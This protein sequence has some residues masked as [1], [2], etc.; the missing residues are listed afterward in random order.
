MVVLLAATLLPISYSNAS[1]S[2]AEAAETPVYDR[3][4]KL[5]EQKPTDSVSFR[6]QAHGGS[7]FDTKRGQLILFGS[8]THGQDWTNSP[9]VF[10][11]NTRQWRRIHANDAPTTYAVNEDGI[12][13]AGKGQHPWAMHAFGAVLYDPARDEMIVASAPKHNTER[14][15]DLMPQI[16]SFPTWTFNLSTNRWH[17]LASKAVDFFPYCAAIDSDRNVVLGYREDGIY[18]LSGEPRSW[19]RLTK[20][21]YLRGYHNNCAYDTKNKALVIF[22]TSNQKNDVEVYFPANGTHQLMP[23][24][25]TRPPKD[26]HTPMTFHPGIGKTIV[27][28]D[29]QLDEGK[30]VGETW[31]Y[32]LGQDFWTQMTTATLP[33]GCG[34]NY[35][36]EYDAHYDQLLLVTGKNSEATT[37]W[38]L[39]IQTSP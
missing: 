11:V 4:V 12:P 8:D 34:M 36:L 29:R 9:L 5:H 18:E 31:L 37:V 33:F 24:P 13:V 20:K 28:V 14:F 16:R 10:D 6:R 25:G 22:G 3:W 38:T 1:G 19:K 26:Q 7:C 39:K 30:I 35:N 2:P 27:I 17:P 21:V 32:D 15:K 23:T